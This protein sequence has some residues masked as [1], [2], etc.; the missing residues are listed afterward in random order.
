MIN[1]NELSWQDCE[2]QT[3]WDEDLY[4]AQIARNPLNYRRLFVRY[5]DGTVVSLWDIYVMRVV[6]S[7]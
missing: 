2:V 6:Y 1:L 5:L 7:A 4:I 3:V